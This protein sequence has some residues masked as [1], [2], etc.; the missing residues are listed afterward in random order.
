M[1]YAEDSL[2]L[3]ACDGR[4]F[5]YGRKRWLCNH[6]SSYA[7][8]RSTKKSR[9]LLARKARPVQAEVWMPMRLAWSLSPWLKV[10]TT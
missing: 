3:M 1:E 2:V 6:I 8:Q 10:D 7:F 9:S 4:L 5:L